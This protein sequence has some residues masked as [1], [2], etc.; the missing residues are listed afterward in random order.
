MNETQTVTQSLH[1]VDAT[2]GS[3]K[4]CAN[5]NPIVA[6]NIDQ[7][8]CNIYV[9]GRG[10]CQGDSGGPLLIKSNSESSTAKSYVQIGIA[11]Y[12]WN[13]EVNEIKCNSA[14]NTGYYMRA[15]YFIPWISSTTG[16]SVD[17]F[18]V[19]S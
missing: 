4:Y 17:A 15:S 19:N 13:R 1:V 5:D 10:V 2:L 6:P 18:T 16:M 7:F 12:I 9:Y 11:S 14:G 3:N 8:L